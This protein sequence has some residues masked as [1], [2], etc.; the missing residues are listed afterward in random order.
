MLINLK[1]KNRK[2]KIDVEVC[3]YKFLGLMFSRRESAKAL[4]FKFKKE[5]RIS[6]HSFFCPR[7]L[8]VWLDKN[9]N[10][11]E[12]KKVFPWSFLILPKR[13]FSRLVEIPCNSKYDEI[14]KS[15][16]ED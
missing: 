12:M 1:F 8:A 13:K 5:V 14:L 4:L 16:D 3:K 7:F 15:L 2:I 9:N 11:L 6:I 10:I